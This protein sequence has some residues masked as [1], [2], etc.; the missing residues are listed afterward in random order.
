[1]SQIFFIFT[2]EIDHQTPGVIR[3]DNWGVIALTKNTK[4]TAH[5]Y[6]TPLYMG[7]TSVY[8]NYY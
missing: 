5:Q 2:V 1:M 7:I 8:S 6:S 4:D 3:G